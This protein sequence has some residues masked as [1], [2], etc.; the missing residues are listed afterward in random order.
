MAAGARVWLEPACGTG[1]YLRI[2]ARGGHRVIGFDLSETMIEYAK[3][4]VPG[5]TFLVADMTRFADAVGEGRVGFAFNLINTIRHLE[6]DHAMLAHFREMRRVLTPRGV[7]AVGISLTLYN[8]EF[9]SE[10]VWEG[11]RGPCRIRQIV[12][13]E[14]PGAGERTE[15]VY[16]HL[17]IRRGQREEH[18]DSTYGLR[19]YDKDQWLA[20]VKKGGFEIARVVDED[21]DEMEMPESGYG[22]YLLRA[23]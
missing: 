14:P 3:S 7:Y 1:R 18:R 17:H 15:H 11:G 23:R 21:G 22:I 19:T 16:S 9:P 2:A 5:G 13:Y 4:R 10:D 6:T 20:V 8:A 12:Q